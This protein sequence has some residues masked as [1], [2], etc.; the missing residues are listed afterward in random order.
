MEEVHLGSFARAFAHPPTTP[1][2][3]KVP[4]TPRRPSLGRWRW[5]STEPKVTADPPLSEVRAASSRSSR[6]TRARTSSCSQLVPCSTRRSRAAIANS[7]SPTPSPPTR[8][9][10]IAAATSPTKWPSLSRHPRSTSP[11]RHPV[12][13]LRPRPSARPARHPPAL[14][15]RTTSS[16]G[17]HPPL[18]RRRRRRRASGAFQLWD[19]AAAVIDR[20]VFPAAKAPAGTLNP[21]DGTSSPS[22]GWRFAVEPSRSPWRADGGVDARRCWSLSWI[23]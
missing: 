13:S 6:S 23:S 16:R 21:L 7:A 18:R 12:R 5:R 3:R 22:P 20:V 1:P 15:R 11:R 9:P 8:P 2:P 10:P 14:P 19:V 4:P 17:S